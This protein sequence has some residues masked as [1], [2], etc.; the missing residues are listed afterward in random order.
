MPKDVIITPANSYVEFRDTNSNVDAM[1]YLDN[2]RNLNI[3]NPNGSLTLGNTAANVYIGDGTSVVDIIFEQNGSVRALTGKTLTLGQSDSSVAFAGNVTNGLRVTSGNVG[4]G[5]TTPLASL[6]VA[7]GAIMPAV[8]NSATAGIQFPSDP[9]GG[10]GDRA[11]IRYFARTGESMTLLLGMENDADDHIAAIP[12]GNFGVGLI[13]PSS[14]LHVVGN[15]NITT[16]INTTTINVTTVNA[17]TL[18]TSAGINVSAAALNAYGQA[19]SGVTIAGNAYGQANNARDQANTARTQ[20]N[21]AYDQANNARGQANTAYAQANTAANTTRVF[22]NSGSQLNAVAL[23][24]VNTATVTVSVAAGSSGNA[25]IAFTAASG[26]G[27]G[28][29]AF[30]LHQYGL[31]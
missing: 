5:T 11:Y 30:I 2:S 25:N 18:L 19:N 28:A 10:S 12:G 15:A 1:I 4:I 21:T 14:K 6:Q 23:N 8:G 13:D 27:G 31:T 20:A 29:E 9:G 16:G 26:G 3:Q 22:A 17:A 7:N 24:F